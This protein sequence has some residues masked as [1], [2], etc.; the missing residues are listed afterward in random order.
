MRCSI[1][2][3]L[4]DG[5]REATVP[6]PMELMAVLTPDD[7]MDPIGGDMAFQDH[8]LVY[9]HVGH[10]VALS[11]APPNAAG[12]SGRMCSVTVP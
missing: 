8:R 6:M 7:D 10:E 1:P 4:A 9:D 2:A 12:K 11:R 3:T 5:H